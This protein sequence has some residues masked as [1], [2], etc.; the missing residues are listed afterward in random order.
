MVDPFLDARA[1]TEHG[2]QSFLDTRTEALVRLETTL[3]E[4]GDSG[5]AAALTANYA[6]RY[7]VP[8]AGPLMAAAAITTV[9]LWRGGLSRWGF[10]GPSRERTPSAT[11]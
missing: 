4:P 10:A 9:Q 2:T 11:E 6:G 1:R 5:V 7:L 8:T 3:G